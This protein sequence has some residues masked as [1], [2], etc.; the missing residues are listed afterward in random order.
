[1]PRVSYPPLNELG[2]RMLARRKILERTQ[3]I[4][5]ARAKMRQG[6][7]CSIELGHTTNPRLDTLRKIAAGLDCTVGDLVD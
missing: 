6:F 1:M 5:C 7:Y 4:V 3:E 2:R